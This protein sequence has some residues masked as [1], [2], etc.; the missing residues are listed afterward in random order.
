MLKRVCEA[1]ELSDVFLSK[2]KKQ[3]TEKCNEFALHSPQKMDL[4]LQCNF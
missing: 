4:G 2:K 1:T 3:P